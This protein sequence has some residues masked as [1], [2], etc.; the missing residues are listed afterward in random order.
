MEFT[1]LVRFDRE[2]KHMVTSVN[3]VRPSTADPSNMTIRPMVLLNRM[4]LPIL[5]TL[6]LLLLPSLAVHGA[7]TAKAEQ[8]AP[9]VPVSTPVREIIV[10]CKNHFDIGYTHR[11][12]EVVR[13]YRTEMID[14]ALDVMD[15]FKGLPPEEQFAWTVPGWVMA[16]V[17]DDWPGQTPHRRQ[18]LEA[19]FKSGKFIAL[20]V[21][22]TVQAEFMEAEELARGWCSRRPPAASMV[23]RCRALRK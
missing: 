6:T 8:A 12:Q 14:R 18:R 11:P 9:A 10:V 21:P 15:K 23:C 3:T 4:W 20:A 5:G 22:F 17:L 19:A 1:Y 2:P 13:Y 7:D 16:K